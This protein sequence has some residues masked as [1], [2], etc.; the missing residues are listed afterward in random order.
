M[1]REYLSGFAGLLTGIVGVVAQALADL[2]DNTLFVINRN[3]AYEMVPLRET[4]Y[5]RFCAACKTLGIPLP[6]LEKEVLEYYLPKQKEHKKSQIESNLKLAQEI[7]ELS[8]C[9]SDS[10]SV[11]LRA[12]ALILETFPET[13]P[14]TFDG[15]SKKNLMAVVNRALLNLGKEPIRF[16]PEL[17]MPPENLM[18]ERE[19]LV[20]IVDD[21]ASDIFKTALALAGWPKLKVEWEH[22]TTDMGWEPSDEKKEQEATRLIEAIVARNPDIILMDQGLSGIDG[23]DLVPRLR[24]RLP[25]AVIVANTGGSADKLQAAGAIS[26]ANKGESMRNAMRDAMYYFR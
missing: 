2:L 8:G 18:P 21:K 5:N 20:L 16:L 14:D 1:Y 13:G 24:R 12:V 19:L 11:L 17:C 15:I 10:D 25:S 6:P 7:R 26:S 23:S 3:N 22:Q 4:A 9:S